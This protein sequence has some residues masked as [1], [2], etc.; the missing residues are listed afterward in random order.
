MPKRKL[1]VIPEPSD[2]VRTILKSGDPSNT[3][4]IRSQGNYDLLCGKCSSVLAKNVLKDQ[5]QNVVLYCNKCRS[6]ND[7]MLIH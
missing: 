5:V 4:I 1:T 6:Y 3:V 7:T 2:K